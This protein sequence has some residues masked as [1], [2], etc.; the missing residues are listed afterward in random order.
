MRR[1]LFCHCWR[2]RPPL[3]LLMLPVFLPCLDTGWM[4]YYASR[5]RTHIEY[6]VCTQ[7]NNGL[8]NF[9]WAHAINRT[10]EC[11][12]AYE[13]GTP[14]SAERSAAAAAMAAA[15]TTCNDTP[16]QQV[17]LALPK[18]ALLQAPVLFSERAANVDGLDEAAATRSCSVS[19]RCRIPTSADLHAHMSD[20]RNSY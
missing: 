4:L 13:T 6:V 8:L 10:C 2:R 9:D 15:A 16:A 5:A 14:T 20:V 17:V 1:S 11:E 7:S 3:L 18:C 12:H 19:F